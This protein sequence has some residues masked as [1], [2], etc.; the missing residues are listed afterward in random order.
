MIF[1][2]IGMGKAGSTTI[3]KFLEVNRSE[4]DKRGFAVIS[5]AAGRAAGAKL[6]FL[7]AD[8]AAQDPISRRNGRRAK[9]W[10]AR[11]AGRVKAAARTQHVILS[12]ET[13]FDGLDDPAL[14]KA[15]HLLGKDTRIIAY[16]RRQDDLLA[17]VWQQW[18]KEG[19][20]RTL[21]ETRDALIG[22]AIYDYYAILSRWKAAFGGLDVR[23]FEKSSF[24]GGDLV[25]DF[26]SAVGID[27]IGLVRPE[28]QNLA[29]DAK[30]SEILR[31]ANRHLPPRPGRDRLIFA[32]PRGGTPRTLNRVQAEGFMARWEAQNR[33]VA[34][35]FLGR[36][37]LFR[38]PPRFGE[39]QT[40]VRCDDAIALLANAWS[41]AAAR[42]ESQIRSLKRER[43]RPLRDRVER[44]F[45][46]LVPAAKP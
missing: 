10:Q 23:A 32:L 34:Q 46:Q 27:P 33:R 21:L 19:E 35:E 28:N 11:F 12:E 8:Q 7:D 26:C 42:Y 6:A 9:A 41:D 3:Q 36:E 2:H 25:T 24:A 37:V 18:L 43:R 14:A 29:L 31:R 38:D 13:C 22:T 17:S 30:T 16:V 45:R 39:T 44:V 5:D 4:L 1:F 20:T 40:A 15:R